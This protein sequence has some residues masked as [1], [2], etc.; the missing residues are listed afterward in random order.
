MLLPVKVLFCNTPSAM[1]LSLM[2][3]RNDDQV[4]LHEMAHF[5]VRSET[6][7]DVRKCQ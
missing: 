1:E 2:S 4:T 5:A 7:A 3:R 6:L